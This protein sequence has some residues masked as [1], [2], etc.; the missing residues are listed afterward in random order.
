MQSHS[1]KILA[2]CWGGDRVCLEALPVDNAG[3]RL[4]VLLLADPH[5]LE[6]GERSQDG[7]SN[8]YRVFPLWRSNDL[9]GWQLQISWYTPHNWK[10]R[11]WHYDCFHP[12][13]GISE[14]LWNMGD[15]WT[16]VFTLIFM[17]VGARAVISFCIRSAMPGYIVVPP[18]RTVLAYRSLR[19]STSHFMMLLK[20]VSWIPQD[21]MPVEWRS[22]HQLLK[23]E[24]YLGSSWMDLPRKEGWKR[25]SGQRNLSFP[26]VMT[27]PSGSS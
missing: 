21:S 8:P 16:P 24:F 6:G 11:P 12:L 22:G 1:F 23:F 27:C 4:V 10:T 26:I 17:V 13:G 5:L 18:D 15:L 9:Q 2:V 19:M 14:N 7:A 20:V 3:A 25:D